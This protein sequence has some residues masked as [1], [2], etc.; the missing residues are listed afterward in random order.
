MALSS[1]LFLRFPVNNL[2]FLTVET[3][4]KLWKPSSCDQR[5]PKMVPPRGHGGHRLNHGLAHDSTPRNSRSGLHHTCR[6]LG[7]LAKSASPSR[8]RLLSPLPQTFTDKMEEGDEVS[9]AEAALNTAEIDSLYDLDVQESLFFAR[10]I[11]L[12]RKM[13]REGPRLLLGRG[14]RVEAVREVGET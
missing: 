3:K 8:V 13:K 5:T 11:A 4:I 12:D 14:K 2:C 6:R 10:I 1:N 7:R 9:N